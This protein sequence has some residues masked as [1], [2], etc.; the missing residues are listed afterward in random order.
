MPRRAIH[1]SNQPVMVGHGE[2][3]GATEEEEGEW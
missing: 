1:P 2:G 3:N